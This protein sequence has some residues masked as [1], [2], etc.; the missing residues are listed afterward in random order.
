MTSL[1]L[2]VTSSLRVF[3]TIPLGMISLKNNEEKLLQ[4]VSKNY[5]GVDWTLVLDGS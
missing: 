5:V 4:I 3:Y 2:D 1:S